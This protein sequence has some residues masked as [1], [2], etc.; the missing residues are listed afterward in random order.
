M[1]CALSES[2]SCSSGAFSVTAPANG[3]FRAST[4]NGDGT[5]SPT[6][7][8]KREHYK[9]YNTVTNQVIDLDGASTI[10][11]LKTNAAKTTLNVTSS[12]LPAQ[13]HVLMTTVDINA[14]PAA[15]SN[16]RT[17]SIQTAEVSITG[18]DGVLQPINDTVQYVQANQ[19]A[20]QP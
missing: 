12:T 19:Q 5:F 10:V 11:T 7:S 14:E 16:I 6:A 9:L 13:L 1:Y 3:K 15:G 20:M 8:E 17:K 4:D 18:I 2:A